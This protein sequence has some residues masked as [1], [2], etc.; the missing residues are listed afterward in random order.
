M[1]LQRKIRKNEMNEIFFKFF[2]TLKS[3]R[4]SKKRENANAIHM[5]ENL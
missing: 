2:I 3:E 5:F 4:K 1:E